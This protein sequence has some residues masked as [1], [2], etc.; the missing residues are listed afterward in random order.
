MASKRKS[1]TGTLKMVWKEPPPAKR[2]RGRSTRLAAFVAAL[3]ERPNEWAVYRT[4]A[5][6]ASPVTQFGK[7]FKGTE[8]TSRKQPNGL[9]HIYARYIGK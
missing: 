4:D 1:S 5:T 2:G 6:N 8:W 3:K 7:K 9:F